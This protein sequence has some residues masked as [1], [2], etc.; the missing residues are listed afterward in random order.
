ML[1]C[2]MQVAAAPRHDVR[3]RRLWYRVMAIA[4][5][6]LMITGPQAWTLAIMAALVAVVIRTAAGVGDAIRPPV[7]PFI[8]AAFAA[9]LIGST[10]ALGQLDGPA[11]ISVSVPAA[12]R[13]WTAL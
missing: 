4:A 6:C 2:V 3:Q 10:A 1:I 11:C 8:F 12:I 13:E 9:A 7:V 5:G